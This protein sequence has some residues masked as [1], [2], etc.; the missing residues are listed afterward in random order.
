VFSIELTSIRERRKSKTGSD[1]VKAFSENKKE[2]E[3]LILPLENKMYRVARTVLHS[4]ADCADAIQEALLRAWK[5]MPQLK[6]GSLFE[7]WLMRILLREC[8]RLIGRN[9][10]QGNVLAFE[11]AYSGDIDLSL[12]MRRMLDTLPYHERIVL[13]LHYTL[14][15][16]VKE[17]ADMLSI[18]QGTVKS[19]LARGRQ[20]LAEKIKE[21]PLWKEIL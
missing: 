7:P 17:V 6:D 4:D 14:D 18:P 12:D 13:I 19:R 3:R 8:Y 20:H 11:E 16:G 1:A 5:K 9:K 21:E 2:F 10:N 15:Y